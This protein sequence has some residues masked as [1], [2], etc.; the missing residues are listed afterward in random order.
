MCKIFEEVFKDF[1]E[2]IQKLL[3]EIDGF[4]ISDANILSQKYSPGECTI[5]LFL[6]KSCLDSYKLEEFLNQIM[7]KRSTWLV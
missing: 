4:C 1:E 6:S 7:E 2:L 5:S 3:Y